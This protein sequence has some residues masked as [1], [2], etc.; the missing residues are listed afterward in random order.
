MT[1]FIVWLKLEY[2]TMVTEPVHFMT[3]HFYLPSYNLL[4]EYQQFFDS[5]ILGSRY[6]IF[7]AAH[8]CELTILL[9]FR[10]S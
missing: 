7:A 9:A 8:L 2:I 6:T 3:L 10:I 4:L 1:V 5:L